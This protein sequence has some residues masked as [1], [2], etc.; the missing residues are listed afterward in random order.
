MLFDIDETL[1]PKKYFSLV[2]FPCGSV[3][4]I[5][6]IQSKEFQNLFNKKSEQEKLHLLFKKTRLKVTLSHMLKRTRP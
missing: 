3:S 1:A 2:F 5:Y 6:T 4:V